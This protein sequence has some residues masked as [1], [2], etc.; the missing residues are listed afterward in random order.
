MNYK[1]LITVVCFFCMREF[2][3]QLKMAVIE[4]LTN[5][6]FCVWLQK[7]PV[8]TLTIFQQSYGD[9]SMKMSQV[10][11]WYK[12][13]HDGRESFD[14]DPRSG[15]PSMSTNEARVKRVREIVKSDRRKYVDQ[16]ASEVRISVESF[17]RILHD[18]LN[19]RRVCQHLVS[20]LL[21]LEQ[22][23]T[24]MSISGDLIDMADRKQVP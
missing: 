6:K 14:D 13:F 21:T 2:A 24:H 8:E 15:R 11:D 17:Q 22:K 16:I 3:S 1:G 18:M 9:R 10:R 12:R 20:R 7:F 23:E 5:I 4:Q 19:V